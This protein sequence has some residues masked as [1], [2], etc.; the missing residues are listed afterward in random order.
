[1][2]NKTKAKMIRA[3]S[4]IVK[5]KVKS[6]KRKSTS[7]KTFNVK[8][9]KRRFRK[10]GKKIKYTPIGTFQV[11]HD[12]LGNFR[13]SKII[14]FKTKKLKKTKVPKANIKKKS[15]VKRKRLSPLEQLDK[16][17]A[18]FYLGKIAEP[19]WLR[20]RKNILSK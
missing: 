6:Y 12:E 18:D 7:G 11:A 20:S 9:Y 3:P 5:V 10:L 14:P 1:M 13:G 16:T 2:K 19:E 17:D 15:R 4:K 8:P